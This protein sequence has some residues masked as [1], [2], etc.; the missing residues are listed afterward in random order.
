MRQV[1]KIICV[2]ILM[3]F[4]CWFQQKQQK[5]MYFFFQIKEM[6]HP[7]IK[8]HI[9]NSVNLVDYI[10][11]FEMI[12]ALNSSIFLSFYFH[13]MNFPF[14]TMCHAFGFHIHV[15]I[16]SILVLFA[17]LFIYKWHGPIPINLNSIQKKNIDTFKSSGCCA[18]SSST[19]FN[20]FFALKF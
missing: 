17:Y 1:K 11:P 6:P 5:Y 20:N 3:E 7:H 19:S 2:R 4:V 18:V 14:W 12:F 15:F 10:V 8:T 16:F 9:H 13:K